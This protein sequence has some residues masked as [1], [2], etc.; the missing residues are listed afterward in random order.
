MFAD[1]FNLALI[2]VAIIGLC[3][4]GLTILLYKIIE[5]PK[6]GAEGK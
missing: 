5:R 3:G 2:V 4:A 6:K 1:S